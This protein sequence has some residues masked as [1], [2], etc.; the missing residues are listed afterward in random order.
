[1]DNDRQAIRAALKC[2]FDIDFDNPRIIRI[3]NTLCM[4]EMYISEAMLPE[5][6]ANPNIEI[7]GEPEEFKFDE[8]G[9]LF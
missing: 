9:N 2:S 6:Q 5:A 4:G 3:H 1:M 7:I 8:N